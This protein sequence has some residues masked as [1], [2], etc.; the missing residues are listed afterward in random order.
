MKIISLY[1]FLSCFAEL[2][3]F[4]DDAACCCAAGGCKRPLPKPLAFNNFRSKESFLGKCSASKPT[5]FL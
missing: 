2:V 5:G 1:F 3:V 4:A